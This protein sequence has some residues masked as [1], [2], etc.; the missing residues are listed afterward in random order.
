MIPGSPKRERRRS[1]IRDKLQSL[2]IERTVFGGCF[3]SVPI[4]DRGRD[5]Q[6]RSGRDR[7]WDRKGTG[8]APEQAR[9]VTWGSLRGRGLADATTRC[10]GQDQPEWTIQNLR[11]KI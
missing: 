2:R 9:L 11:G 5:R 10:Y 1:A 8:W 4:G 6:E 3:L 7:E